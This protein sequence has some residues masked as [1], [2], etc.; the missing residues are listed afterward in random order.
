MNI[1]YIPPPS[2]QALNWRVGVACA[3]ENEAVGVTLVLTLGA[4]LERGG[5]RSGRRRGR[6]G[7]RRRGSVNGEENRATKPRR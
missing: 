5:Q 1:N 7:R 2:L 6:R 4:G 3:L